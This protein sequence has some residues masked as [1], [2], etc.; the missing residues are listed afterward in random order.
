MCPTLRI[1]A[2]ATLLVPAGVA[3]VHA[4]STVRTGS[5]EAGDPTLESGESFDEYP[6]D[7][8]AGQEIVA[9]VSSVDFDPYVIAI[10]PSGEQFENDDYGESS[11]V[12][13]VQTVA[14]EGGAWRV[15][16]TSYETGESGDYAVVY[17]T[18]QRTDSETLDEEF[19]VSGAIPADRAA[20][21]SGTLDENDSARED[22]SW[23][24]AWSIDLEAGSNVLFLLTSPD[25]DAYLT[26]VSPTRRAFS[27]DDGAGGT[28]SRLDMA[29]DESGRWTVV[30]NTLEA[31]ESGD[32]TLSVQRR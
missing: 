20:S 32:Y 13:L 17:A 21:V 4:Q 29:V 8:L 22:G 16:V 9:V 24:E 28:D 31:G 1:L 26:L 14:G 11:D 30:A 25:F 19:T 10:A 7:V 12:A 18:R 2:L 6:L 5:L 27:D 15:R 23:Y 3:G